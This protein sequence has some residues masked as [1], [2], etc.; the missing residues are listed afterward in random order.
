MNRQAQ[1]PAP[2]SGP[3]SPITAPVLPPLFSGKRR[4]LIVALVLA[5]FGLATCSVATALLMAWLLAGGRDNVALP[6]SGLTAAILGI[7][8]LQVLERVLAE[9]LG[10]DYVQQIREKLIRESLTPGSQTSL[11]ITIARTTNDLSSIRNWIVLG[12]APVIAGVPVI[13][14]LGA[15][16]WILSPPLAAAGMVPLCLLGVVLFLLRH[17]AFARAQEVRRRRGRLAARVADIVSAAASVQAAGGTRREVRRIRSLGDQLAAAA[18][19]QARTA[20]YLRASAAV[21]ASAS[22]AAVAGAGA[23][24][25]TDTSII[26]AALTAVGMMSAPVA[27]TGRII[28]YRQKFRAAR[29]II[30]P[31]MAAST[32]RRRH[33][34]KRNTANATTGTPVADLDEGRIQISGLILADGTAVEPLQAEAGDR[35]V[36]R[37]QNPARSA[38]VCQAILGLL[39]DVTASVNINGYDLLAMSPERRR[40]VIGFACSGAIL[41]PGTIS[42]TLRYRRPDLPDTAT[43]DLLDRVGL[44][45]RLAGLEAGVLTRLRRGG[46]PLTRS[47]LAR[48]QLA[49]SLLGDPPLIVLDHIDADLGPHGSDVIGAVLASYPGVAIIASEIPDALPWKAKPW[50]IDLPNSMAMNPRDPRQRAAAG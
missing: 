48:L 16:L 31:L 36:I 15:A 5:A 29:T 9:K 14:G 3:L 40:A 43:G 24:L 26:A 37:S 50:H 20:G 34:H 12:L 49:S 1:G 47:D 22:V 33:P 8:F 42:R 30:A 21:A 18:V 39:P 32:A 23:G 17:P 28:E 27:E 25:N 7:G 35:I 45:E 46:A 44:T 13:A 38:Q 19:R 10:Q 2:P 4:A 11:G 41:A 6:L